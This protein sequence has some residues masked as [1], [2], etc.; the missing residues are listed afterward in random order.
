MIKNI[1][2]KPAVKVILNA[3]S[4]EL[5]PVRSGTWQ[6]CPIPPLLSDTTLEVL[7]NAIRQEIQDIQIVREEIKLCLFADDIIIYVE[8][9]KE[10]TK[11]CY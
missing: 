4:L 9:Q 6:G 1:Y 8:S 7:A 5:F 10:V 3:E 2:K 11:N